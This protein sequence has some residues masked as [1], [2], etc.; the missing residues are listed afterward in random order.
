[1]AE[2]KGAHGKTADALRKKKVGVTVELGSIGERV[3]RV[4]IAMTGARV[5]LNK[6]LLYIRL[7]KRDKLNLL[8]TILNALLDECIGNDVRAASL[9]PKFKAYRDS[10]ETLVDAKQHVL[11]ELLNAHEPSIH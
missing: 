1:M 4:S 8:G 10:G 3:A 7:V 6:D 2:D 9:F 11:Y 5:T